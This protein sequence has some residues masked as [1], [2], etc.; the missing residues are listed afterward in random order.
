MAATVSQLIAV[1]RIVAVY[2]VKGWVKVLSSTEPSGNIFSYQPW[3]VDAQNARQLLRVDEYR[4]HGKGYVAHISG[5]D[6]RDIAQTVCRKDIFVEK[7]LLPE[8]TEGE[9]Y[10]H[11]LQGLKVY[12]VANSPGAAA[13]ER[14]FLG[15][16]AGFMETGAND[17]LV[18]KSCQGSLDRRERLIPW[19][20]EYLAKVDVDSGEIEVYWDSSF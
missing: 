8:L 20:D 14:E 1:G 3:Y 4:T 2:G 6:D 18:I 10:W 11:Q 19:L 5:I 7:S 9:H 13:I 16:V 17:V 12:S 15:E